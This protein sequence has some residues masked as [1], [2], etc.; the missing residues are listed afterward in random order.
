M[1]NILKELQ[2]LSLKINQLKPIDQNHSN[3]LKDLFTSL[4]KAQGEME[5]ASLNKENPFFKTRYSDFASVVKSTRPSLTKYGLSVCQTIHHN[6]DGQL[7]LT[8]RLAHSTGQWIDSKV[9]I[10]PSKNDIQTLGSYL[11]YMKRYTYASIVG[12]IDGD[13]D[14]GERAMIDA[15][16]ILAKG[17]SN[18]YDARNESPDVIT[19]EQLEELE[20]ELASHPDLAEEIMDKLRIQSLADLPKSKYMVSLKR[21][22]EIKNARE[23]VK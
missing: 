22:R 9:R 6:D 4:A 7:W 19:K 3:D 14:D 17:P 8:T 16:E 15:R 21:I 1:E 10:V 13:D 23:G 11:T 20:Y 2:A 12:S 18:R 5:S